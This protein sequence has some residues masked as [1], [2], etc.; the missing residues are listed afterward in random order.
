MNAIDVLKQA[1]TVVIKI[2]SVLIY[3]QDTGK[4]RDEWFMAL[5][6]DVRTL[7]DQGKRV[8]IVSSGGIALGRKALGISLSARPQSIPLEHKQAA[9]AVGQFHMFN[10]YYR[11]FSRFEQEVAQVLLTMSE[12]ENRRMH[13][14]ARETLYTLLD[15]GIIPIINE[16][17]TVSTGEIRFGDNDRLAVRVGQMID[18]DAVVLFSSTDG[19]YTADPGLDPD[20]KHIPVVEK[21]TED[22]VRMAGDAVPGLSTGGMASKIKA[23]QTATQAGIHLM[24]ANGMEIHSIQTLFVDASARATLFVAQETRAN[25]RQKWIQAHL[26]PKGA[27]QIDEGAIEALRQGRSLLPIGARAV[28]GEFQRGDAIEIKGPDGRRLG[29]GLSAYSSVDA[30]KIIGRKSDEIAGI[31]GYVRRDELIHRNDLVLQSV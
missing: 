25:A 23:A 8:V 30:Q 9:S 29:I 28:T 5:A 6:L 12:T 14:N 19:L 18:A 22:H 17:D 3:D 11:A 15:K 13:I 24:I 4:P 10:A 16:N 31:L 26:K 7:M 2:G 21:I 27:V 20:A 1:K